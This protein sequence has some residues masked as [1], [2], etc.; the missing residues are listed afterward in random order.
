MTDVNTMVE[1]LESAYEAVNL[2]PDNDE[3]GFMKLL[4][5]RNLVP[6]AAALIRSQQDENSALRKVLSEEGLT[7]NYQ[8]DAVTK[9]LEAAEAETKRQFNVG[10]ILACCNLTN[11]HDEPC[12]S[13]DVLEQLG[14]S[15]A[16]VKAM[17]LSEYDT[18]ALR[19]IERSCPSRSLYIDGRRAR[20][21]GRR[22]G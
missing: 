14:I 9:R 2:W 7:V 12:M 16:E 6:E 13:F 11:L 18:K 19:K 3:N 1:Q 22:E 15:R 10:Y 4:E 17:N 20:A 21:V 5:L 8:V